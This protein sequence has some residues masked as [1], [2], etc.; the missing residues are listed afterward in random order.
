MVAISQI[1]ELYKKNFKIGLNFLKLSKTKKKKKKK[2]NNNNNN[3]NAYM[4]M[5]ALVG[6]R[7][8]EIL[9]LHHGA[10]REWV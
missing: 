4:W 6:W 5:F 10:E 8:G 2:N 7:W 1:L 9:A 3:K